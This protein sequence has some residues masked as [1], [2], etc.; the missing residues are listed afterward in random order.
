VEVR[1]GGAL[2]E[3]ARSTLTQLREL[4]VRLA[5]AGFGTGWSTMSLLSAH[6]WDL[7]SLHPA[8]VATLGHDEHAEAVVAATISMAHALGVRAG[9]DGVTTHEHLERLAELGCDVVRGDYVGL[10]STAERVLA[11][12]DA[13][14]RWTREAVGGSRA[15]RT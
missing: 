12:V 4:G 10:P 5:V 1:H 8:F 6:P 2:D 14:G 11:H 15:A 13:A 9:A 7:L 3:V